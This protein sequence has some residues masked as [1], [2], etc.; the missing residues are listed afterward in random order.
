MANSALLGL[1]LFLGVLAFPLMA[2][3]LPFANLWYNRNRKKVDQQVS[4]V[5][6]RVEKLKTL[7]EAVYEA[8]EQAHAGDETTSDDE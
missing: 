2:V 5:K 6:A 8:D 7:R 3:A 4:S 1:I